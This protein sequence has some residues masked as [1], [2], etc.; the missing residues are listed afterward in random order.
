[1][2]YQ[3]HKEVFSRMNMVKAS[4]S[5][6]V[7][8]F[9]SYVTIMG[10]ELLRNKSCGIDIIVERDEEI[11]FLEVSEALEKKGSLHTVK[12]ITWK[13]NEEIVINPE[14]GWCD[15]LDLLPFPDRN[16][17]PL[18]EYSGMVCRNKKYTQVITSRGCPHRC[19]YCFQYVIE[20]VV[21]K[22][23]PKNVVDEMEYLVRD[24]QIEEIHIE[25]ANFVSGD[26]ERIKN[27]CREILERGLQF[28]WQCSGVIPV[29]E[30]GDVRM[31]DL[32]AQSGC[33]GVSLGIESFNYETINKMARGYSIKL[34][35][36]ILQHCRKNKMEVSCHMIIGFPGQSMDEIK[37]DIRVSRKYPFD[38]IHYN[39]FQNVSS[40]PT[41]EQDDQVNACNVGPDGASLSHSALKNVQRLAYGF[42]I[43]KLSVLKF[44]FRRFWGK[45]NTGVM[46]KKV[47]HYLFGCQKLHLG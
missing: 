15:N 3:N 29:G 20:P 11:T 45:N 43:F 39:I 31:L 28:D 17:F 35:P 24:C 1:I 33:Y 38:F 2:S 10:D 5:L 25:D 16:L 42:L 13:E 37:E 18:E 4:V 8:A 26:S 6:Q 34:L 30:M 23:S 32:M 44:L 22:R 7:I 47:R 12:G 19:T 14:R 46:F 41:H 21:R 36:R 40:A 27:I 9:G